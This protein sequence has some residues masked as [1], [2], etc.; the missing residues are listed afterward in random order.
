MKVEGFQHENVG[1]A[2]EVL[3][4]VHMTK[5]RGLGNWLV[6]EHTDARRN[7]AHRDHV[8]IVHCGGGAVAALIYGN[9]FLVVAPWLRRAL[10]AAR[11]QGARRVAD[12]RGLV[13]AGRLC[14]ARAKTPFVTSIFRML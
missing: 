8:A 12:V 1:Q 6:D 10:G 2:F 4:F 11:T 7:R 5:G 14:S 13:A 9:H 3:A